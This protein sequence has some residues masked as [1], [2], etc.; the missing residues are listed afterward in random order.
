M[1][2]FYLFTSQKLSSL[3]FNPTGKVTRPVVVALHEGLILVQ[4]AKNHCV[5]IKAN[6]KNSVVNL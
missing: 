5:V 2:S 6:A 3:P 1:L 4:C